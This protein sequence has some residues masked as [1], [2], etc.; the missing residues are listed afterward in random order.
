MI[1]AALFY[2]DKEQTQEVSFH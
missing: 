2:H 1:R